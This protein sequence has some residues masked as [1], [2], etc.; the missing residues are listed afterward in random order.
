MYIKNVISLCF[1][2]INRWLLE[3]PFS[4]GFCELLIPLCFQK[5]VSCQ[6][7]VEILWDDVDKFYDFQ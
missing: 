2:W 3:V 7:I 4:L 1:K 6:G 5:V